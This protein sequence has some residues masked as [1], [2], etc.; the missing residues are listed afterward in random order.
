MGA[1]K[2]ALFLQESLIYV[3]NSEYIIFSDFG[4]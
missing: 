2:A 1:A 4:E 3:Q